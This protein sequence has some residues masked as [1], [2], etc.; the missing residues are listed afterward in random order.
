MARVYL[1]S[2]IVIYLIQGSDELNRAVTQALRPTKVEPP[3]AFVSDL[4]R[5]ECRV[6]PIGKADDQLLHQ[7]DEF[8][9]SEDLTTIPITTETFDLA[10]ELRGHM[11]RRRRMRSILRLQSWEDVRSSGRMITV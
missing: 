1:D 8:F 9:A 2:C 3:T 10:T 4:T 5:L 6:W 7:Y 11:A